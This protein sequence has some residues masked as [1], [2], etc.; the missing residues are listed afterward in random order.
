MQSVAFLTHAE[1][2]FVHVKSVESR[3]QCSVTNCR[4]L[5][6]GKLLKARRMYI[7]VHLLSCCL[8]LWKSTPIEKQL[9]PSPT[10][11]MSVGVDH[12]VEAASSVSRM[13]TICL[14]LSKKFPYNVP[15]ES[16]L[17]DL[18]WNGQWLAQGI[19]S[20]RSNL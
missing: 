7:H 3:L 5:A 12:D 9:E 4:I 1:N 20:R 2:G 6:G 15:L 8:G 11:A 14:N 13:A 10:S 19:Y 16:R 18:L 17:Q